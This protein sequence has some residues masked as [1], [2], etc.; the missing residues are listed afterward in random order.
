M[1]RK[2]RLW[3]V[4]MLVLALVAAACGSSDDDADDTTPT[5]AGA[6]AGEGLKMA[7]IFDGQIDDGGWNMRHNVGAEFVQD[8]L[9]GAEIVKIEGIDPGAPM[10]AAMDDFGAQGFDIVVG[11]TFTQFD[12]FEVAPNYPNTVFLTQGG[13]ETMPN[14]GHYEGALEEARYLDGMIA[15][16]MTESNII[17]YSGGFPIEGVVRPI[18][19][20]ARG[21]QETN[22]DAEVVAVFIDSWFDPPKETQAAESLADNGADVIAM[23]LNSPAT[24]QAAARK[25]AR[26]IGYGADQSAYAPDAWLTSFV[27]NW[28]PYY[29]SQ[30]EAV[31]AGT[32]EAEVTFLLMKDGIVSRGPVASDV[33]QSVLD[34]VAEREAQILDGTFDVMAGP[35][36]DNQGNIVV[37]AGETVPPSERTACCQWFYENVVGE[38]PAG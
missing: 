10:Q 38:I 13:F 25:D 20:F 19:T 23:D 11:T 5:T 37:P 2:S 34:L 36:T 6:L 31:L 26:F 12:A 30:A 7:F 24:A 4:V 29:L 21:V 14:V 3:L 1:I 9:P 35:M 15:G 16:A 27:W 18:N 8:A 33:P 28:G 17:G 32:W 22:P